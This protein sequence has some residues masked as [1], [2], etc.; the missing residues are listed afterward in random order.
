MARRAVTIPSYILLAALC[1]FTTPLWIVVTVLFDMASSKRYLFPRTRAAAFVTLYLS[2]EVV[3]ILAALSIGV[4]S[5]DGLFGGN[6]RYRRANA[7]LQRWWTSALFR[8]GTFLFG[9]TSIVENA[10]VV[11]R[12]PFLLFVRHSSTADTVL[13]AALVAN[14]HGILLRYVI[15]QELLWDPCLDIVGSRL[16]NAFIDRNADRKD[17]E[18]AAVIQLAS[19]LDE[20]SA[21]L[22]YPEGTRFSQAKQQRALATLKDSG[23]TALAEIAST[24]RHVLPPRR[25]G[26]LALLDAAPHVDVVLLEHTGFEGATTLDRFLD[27]K[28]V[29]RTLRVRLRRFEAASIPSEARDTWLFERWREMDDWIDASGSLNGDGA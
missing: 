21:V 19:Q 28:L 5:L 26:P 29:G 12:G 16:P 14:P 13:A 18:V 2:C 27:G 25:R 6:A 1:L 9:I 22:I 17:G 15:K 24:F 20:R 8:G 10:H 23:E 4:L 11:S 7:A 3:G